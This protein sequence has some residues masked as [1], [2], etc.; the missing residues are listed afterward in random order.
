M[1]SLFNIILVALAAVTAGCTWTSH[2]PRDATTHALRTFFS[3]NA[4]RLHYTSVQVDVIDR[5]VFRF[6]LAASPISTTGGENDA[7]HAYIT[8]PILVS[9]VLPSYYRLDATSTP[10]AS[11]S[12]IRPDGAYWILLATVPLPLRPDAHAL[13]G[14]GDNNITL[15]FSVVPQA[16]SDSIPFL[17]PVGSASSTLPA[18]VRLP[19]RWSFAGLTLNAGPISIDAVQLP[20]GLQEG[21]PTAVALLGVNP[22]LLWDLSDVR[23]VAPAYSVHWT[24]ATLFLSLSLALLLAWAVLADMF[25]RQDMKRLN[26]SR[27]LAFRIH[28]LHYR[29]RNLGA[30]EQTGD[31]HPDY[32]Q[33]FVAEAERLRAEALAFNIAEHLNSLALVEQEINELSRRDW[34]HRPYDGFYD[35]GELYDE[36][37]HGR[38]LRSRLRYYVHLHSQPRF[39]LLRNICVGLLFLIILVVAFVIL[40][41]VRAIAKE[42]ASSPI[43]L[44]E[45]SLETRLSSIMTAE[46]RIEIRFVPLNLSDR[47]LNEVEVGIGILAQDRMRALNCAAVDK[48]ISVAYVAGTLAVRGIGRLSPL[49]RLRYLLAFSDATLADDAGYFQ[50]I[51]TAKQVVIICTGT[52][53]VFTHNNGPIGGSI[54]LFPFDTHVV[55]VS[56]ATEGAGMAITCVSFSD[57]YDGAVRGAPPYGA[58]DTKGD[59]I[60][61]CGAGGKRH[62]ERSGVVIE[63]ELGRPWL[64][65]A[66][67][68]WGLVVLGAFLGAV[69]GI[70]TLLTGSGLVQLGAAAA[71]IGGVSAYVWEKVVEGSSLPSL[72]KGQSATIFELCLF[73]ALGVAYVALFVIW[74]KYRSK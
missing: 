63:T 53:G 66:F 22:T 39:L 32:L 61:L 24:R 40:S 12:A 47:V 59:L 36:L 14:D 57:V 50:A 3:E 74:L 49:G 73:G 67:C 52:S 8:I 70:V 10:N 33:A 65:R 9:P 71:A 42:A 25:R 35:D 60:Q 38:N 37:Y 54:N 68:S 6:T 56:L 45:L 72:L 2:E 48:D 34:P 31:T 17:I 29:V 20:A 55:N 62:I 46:E 19:A 15:R 58:W 23:Y 11:L 16:P 1:R 18:E 5:G 28:T 51:R 44:A 27:Y 7:P 4:W 26:Q 64:T 21:V 69:C 13:S 43:M 41:P 30:G